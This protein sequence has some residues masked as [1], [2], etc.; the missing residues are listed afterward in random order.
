MGGGPTCTKSTTRRRVWTFTQPLAEYLSAEHVHTTPTHDIWPGASVQGNLA[1]SLVAVKA[2]GRRQKAKMGGGPTCTKSTTR[3]RV[4]AFTQPLAEYLSAKH[5]H[6]TPTH[7]ILPGASVQGKL[8]IRLV[9]AK[10]EGRRPLARMG[11]A[12]KMHKIHNSSTDLDI[13]SAP[14]GVFECRTHPHHPHT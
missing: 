5:V 1:T 14:G 2:E 9:V 7:D 6:T 8:A 10:A 12:P 13:C 3:R 11:G 4:W